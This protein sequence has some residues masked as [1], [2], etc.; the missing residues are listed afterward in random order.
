MSKR[1]VCITCGG[2]GFRY[3]NMMVNPKPVTC[4]N[5]KGTGY[6]VIRTPAPGSERR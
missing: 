6:H 1:I 5:C 4:D 3:P 2:S